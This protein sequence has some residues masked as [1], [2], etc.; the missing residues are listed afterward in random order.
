MHAII[1]PRTVQRGRP[2]AVYD[3]EIATY[4]RSRKLELIHLWSSS[5]LKE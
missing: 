3:S 4:A 1:V 2:V 5:Q